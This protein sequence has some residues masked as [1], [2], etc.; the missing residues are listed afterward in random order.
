MLVDQRLSRIFEIIKQNEFAEV[1]E[2]ASQLNVST[3]TIRRDLKKLNDQGLILRRHG[4]A[5]TISIMYDEQHY[6]DKQVANPEGKAKIAQTA[7]ALV[8]NGDTIYLDGGTTSMHIAKLLPERKDLTVITNDIM[9]ALE[10][11]ET[12]VQLILLGG[13][14]QSSTKTLGSPLA[15]EVLRKFMV[16]T[17]FIGTSTVNQDFDVFTPTLEKSYLKR[18]AMDIAQKTYLVVDSTKFF[19]QSLYKWGTLSEFSGI[20]TDKYL[21]VDERKLVHK[22]N[23]KIISAL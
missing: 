14:V 17:A 18:T 12:D 8:K 23:V 19:S 5:S 9:I 22:S 7:M 11:S 1:D 10:L 20:I 16:N 6:T 21:S 2:L 3:M 13:T 15:V 4:G